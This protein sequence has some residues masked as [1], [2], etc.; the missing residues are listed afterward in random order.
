[1][2]MSS[3]VRAAWQE[4]D[5]ALKAIGD[6][7]QCL[8]QLQ[9]WMRETLPA[10]SVVTR[11]A[12]RPYAVEEFVR[13][14]VADLPMHRLALDEV[15]RRASFHRSSDPQRLGEFAGTIVEYLVRYVHLDDACAECQYDLV[16]MRRG[17]SRVL[18]H[19]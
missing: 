15:L 9:R 1:M 11:N 5:D 4:L 19:R 6:P 17:V 14:P 2:I 8:R 18:V 16:A 10:T 13:T 3:R 7:E 12:I